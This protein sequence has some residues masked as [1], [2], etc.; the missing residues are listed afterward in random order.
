MWYVIDIVSG[1]S[2]VY[3][4]SGNALSKSKKGSASDLTFIQKMY[5]LFL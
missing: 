1:L 5:S 2:S 4:T 3:V